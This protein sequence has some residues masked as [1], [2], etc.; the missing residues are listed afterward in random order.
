MSEEH[1]TPTRGEFWYW[2]V[3]GGVTLGLVLL[4]AESQIEK[5]GQWS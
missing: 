1:E 4:A 2:A 3:V 5:W